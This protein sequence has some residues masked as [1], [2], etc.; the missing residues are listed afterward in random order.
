MDNVGIILVML[1]ST[2]GP[3]LVIA[4][5]GASALKA[6]ARNPS[7][8]AKI[9]QSMMIAFLCAEAIAVLALLVVYMLFK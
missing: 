5:V 3:S 4:Y 8:S 7:A 9:L 6:L 1:L 2:L